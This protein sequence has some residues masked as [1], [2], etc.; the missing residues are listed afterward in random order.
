MIDLKTKALEGLTQ[1]EVF[2]YESELLE[3]GVTEYW[4]KELEAFCHVKTVANVV[5]K[6]ESTM[7]AYMMARVLDLVA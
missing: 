5:G 7:L 2:E 3:L 1:N 4:D 6:E